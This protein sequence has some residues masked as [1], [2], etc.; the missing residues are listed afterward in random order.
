MIAYKGFEEG[1]ICRGYQFQMGLNV[2]EEANC[3][4]NGFHCA[5]NPLDCLSY[6]R[7]MATSVYCLVE[8]DGDL[9]EDGHDSRISCTHLNI[10]KVLN[11]REFL[12][13]ALAYM[14]DHPRLPTN[15]NVNI[16][17]GL[18][19]DGWAVV[20]GK[21]PLITGLEK[22]DILAFAQ[23]SSDSLKITRI[24]IARVDGEKIM[25]GKQYDIDLKERKE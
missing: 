23:E 2:T 4:A 10:L 12:L 20:R 1:L 19:R 22:G 18:A 16:G 17:R 9:D 15:G 8:A 5:A 24:S 3:A 14:V 11:L 25:P 6:Y 21:D 7:N 13:H